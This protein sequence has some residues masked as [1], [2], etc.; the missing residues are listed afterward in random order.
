MYKIATIHVSGVEARAVDLKKIPL[1]ITG[2]S[3]IFIYDDPMWAGL[4]KNVVF[5]GSETVSILNAGEVVQ[6]PPEVAGAVNQN[7]RVGVCGTNAEGTVII[8]TIWADL[9]SV[10]PS[11][12]G[13][14]PPPAEKHLPVWV[15]LQSMIGDPTNLNTVDKSNLV[16]AVNE[17]LGKVGTGG[18]VSD[19]QIA[20][21]VADYLAENPVDVGVQFETDGSLILE[22]GVLSV[23]TT[24]RM[25]QDNT[26]PITSAGV[27]TTVGNIEALLAT[28]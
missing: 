12:Y 19:E 27:F 22:K 1:N 14:F 5:D 23:N 15:Q 11:A 8:P 10:R 20:Q 9:G 17:V 3:V 7:V 13:S 16:A 25:E 2:A 21:A 4:T 6:F 26:L 28:I 24:D 18:A